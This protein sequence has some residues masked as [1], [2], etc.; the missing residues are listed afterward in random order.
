MAH[1]L[2]QVSYS[3]DAWAALILNPQDRGE[4]VRGPIE[5]LGG[6]IGQIWLAFGDDDIVAIIEMPNNIA[7]AAISMAF[8]AGGACKNV[9]TTPLMSI[10][11]GLE[12][13]KK[14]GECGYQP[15]NRTEP[16]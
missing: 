13:M 9:K 11:E 15:A 5:K 1:Y 4:A 14:A 12:A 7:A 6:K 3:R 2:L 8:S 16:F 10:Q